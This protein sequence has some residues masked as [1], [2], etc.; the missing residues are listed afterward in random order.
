[1][2]LAPGLIDIVNAPTLIGARVIASHPP[3]QSTERLN[4]WYVHH[5]RDKTFR[6]AAPSP[7]TC[8][9][10]TTIS[11]DGAVIA[12][13]EKA[14]ASR[15][16]ILKGSSAVSTELQHAPVETQ[17]RICIGCFEIEIVPESHAYGAA[18]EK[19]ELWRV[20]PFVTYYARIINE[21]SVWL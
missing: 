3:P 6:V 17:A 11:T 1:V 9:R 20:Q 8:N 10:T 14:A 7:T 13:D 19:T 18:L 12:P 15:K 2:P 16:N 5:R 4:R 21:D